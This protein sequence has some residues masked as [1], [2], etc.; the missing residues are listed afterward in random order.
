MFAEESLPSHLGDVK[1][2][3]AEGKCEDFA[4]FVPLAMEGGDWTE[5]IQEFGFRADGQKRPENSG[6]EVAEK[7]FLHIA[8]AADEEETPE[9]PANFYK[10]QGGVE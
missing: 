2:L 5:E 10:A 9:M 4:G 3:L 7:D 8:L 1:F 6:I